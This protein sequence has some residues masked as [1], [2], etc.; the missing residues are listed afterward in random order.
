MT[1]SNRSCRRVLPAIGVIGSAFVWS[2]LPVSAQCLKPTA[3]HTKADASPDQYYI[4][5][6]G[7]KYLLEF[8][9]LSGGEQLGGAPFYTDFT[10]VPGAQYRLQS[11][12]AAGNANDNFDVK[13]ENAV[14]ITNGAAVDIKIPR[15]TTKSIDYRVRA[16]GPLLT[17]YIRS[18]SLG[19]TWSTV[20]PTTLCKLGGS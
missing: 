3:W 9:V 2:V 1:R 17:F 19:K 7:E 6:T 11:T 15:F 13:I 14:D 5:P 16:S 12:I 8:T 20:G 10:V 18:E 4:N